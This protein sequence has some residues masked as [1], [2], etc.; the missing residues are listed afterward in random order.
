M[1]KAYTVLAFCL[2]SSSVIVH[3][4]YNALMVKRTTKLIR[5]TAVRFTAEMQDEIE[6]WRRAQRAIPAKGVAIRTLVRAGLDAYAGKL[7]RGIKP[8]A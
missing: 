4:V 6:D 1:V 3:T 5:L 8:A 7:P 2:N